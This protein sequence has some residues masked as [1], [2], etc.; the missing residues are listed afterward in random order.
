MDR[1][2]VNRLRDGG[3][4]AGAASVSG[5]KWH[6]SIGGDYQGPWDTVE[7]TNQDDEP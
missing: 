7:G 4:D 1:H 3:A 6:R 5:R 2:L